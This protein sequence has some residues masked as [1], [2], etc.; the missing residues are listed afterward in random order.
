MLL[1]Y[2]EIPIKD[3]YKR[4]SIY[5]D[6]WVMIAGGLGVAAEMRQMELGRRHGLR[7]SQ[8]AVRIAKVYMAWAFVM[9]RLCCWMACAPAV[10]CGDS[11]RVALKVSWM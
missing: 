11:I 4:T 5:S 9:K 2:C 8:F 3:I 10:W 6:L 1:N 7:M